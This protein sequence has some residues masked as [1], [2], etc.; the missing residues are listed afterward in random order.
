MARLGAGVIGLGVGERHAH[1]FARLPASELV[2]LCDQDVR[3]LEAIGQKFPGVRQYA[4]A[5]DLIDDPAVSVVSVASYDQDHHRQI[6]RALRL[7]KHVFAE[8]PLCLSEQELE[9][10]HTAW[11]EG[12][13]RVRLT[14][15]T[16]LRRSPRFVWLKDAIQRGDMGRVYCI[17]A[18]YLYGRLHKLTDGW[19]GRIPGYSVML[20]GGVHMID[21]VLWL[22][23][24][25]PVEVTA[26]GSGLASQKTSF[27]GNDMALALLRFESGL[28]VKIG[29]NFASV[30]PHY[31]RLFVYGTQATFAN[32][33]E[34]IVGPALFWTDRDP[35]RPPKTVDEAYPGVEK[36]DLLP[37]FLDAIQ[38][39][40][41]PDV[42]EREVF[43]TLATCLAIE[44]SIQSGGAPVRVRYPL[45]GA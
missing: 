38:G 17:E 34:D 45:M 37:A 26:F 27:Q 25:Q 8:K 36:G 1:A 28:L 7:G 33:L 42:T 18:D 23:G 32:P 43:A 19:R 44:A 30:H 22:T 35:G 3:R 16:V 24:E 2:A 6:V 9:A 31:H 39:R 10:I 13:G 5:D 40:G 12:N 15:N 11:R 20:G 14:T 41:E 4:S 29:A 21:L